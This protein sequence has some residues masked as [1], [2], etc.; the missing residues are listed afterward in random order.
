MPIVLLLI[1]A[2]FLTAAIRGKESVDLLF[3]TLKD[4]FAGPN[5]FVAWIV[6][7]WVITSLGYIKAIKPISH[8]FLILVFLAMFISA[9]KHGKDFFSSF[10]NQIR[11]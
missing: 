11:G 9:N 10:R 7:I 5:N 2:I 8:A 4:D 1:G 3:A 6:A